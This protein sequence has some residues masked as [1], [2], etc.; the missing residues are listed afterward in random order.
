LFKEPIHRPSVVLNA[1][2]KK[3]SFWS[4]SWFLPSKIGSVLE[5]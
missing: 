3:L 5:E 1:K 4:S 2:S